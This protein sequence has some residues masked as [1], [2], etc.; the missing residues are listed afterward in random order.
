MTKAEKEKIFEVADMVKDIA[1][2]DEISFKR[3]KY[4]IS[5]YYRTKRKI[6]EVCKENCLDVGTFEHHK[7]II[8][9]AVRGKCESEYWVKSI[10]TQMYA[11]IDAERE[12]QEGEKTDD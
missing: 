4:I 9:K 1:K 6:E 11:E 3:I 2:L 7:F 5:D 10:L 8:E 12:K